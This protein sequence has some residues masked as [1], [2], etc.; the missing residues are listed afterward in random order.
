MQSQTDISEKSV[1]QA[2]VNERIN[3]NCDNISFS[4]SD[5]F[6][7]LPENKFKTVVFNPPGWRTPSQPFLNR[8]E[9]TSNAAQLP[10]R[11]MFY[12]DEVITRFLD[13]LPEY[14]APTG[15]AIVGLNSLVGIRDVLHRYNEKHKG[16]PPLRHRLVERHTLPLIHYSAQWFLLND[17]L[18]DEFEC[19][20]QQDLAAF[21][22]DQDGTVYWS[23][24][25]IEFV[26][27]SNF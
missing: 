17:Q 4:V 20:E 2:R 22:T 3:F 8:L 27:S 10:V 13:Q 5:L 1:Q 14:L 7:S 23:Y 18:K 12:G 21:S 11:A 26:H 16:H 25:I 24:E 19:W 9:T 6:D 15:K